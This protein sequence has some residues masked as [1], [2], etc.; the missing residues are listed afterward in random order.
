MGPAPPFSSFNGEV[1]AL[2]SSMSRLDCIAG[3]HM[4]PGDYENREFTGPLSLTRELPW[5]SPP[6]GW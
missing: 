4:E 3:K 1:R 2:S 6:S 5:S